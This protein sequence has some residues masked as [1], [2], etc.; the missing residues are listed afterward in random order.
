MKETLFKKKKFSLRFIAFVQALGLV[1]YC[2]LVALLF[3]RGEK[4]FGPANNFFMPAFLLVI[5]AT[6]A[7]ICGLLVLGYPIILF[8]FKKEKTGALKLVVYTAAWLIF[9]IFLIIPILVIF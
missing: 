5:F 1:V 7:L 8:W 6:S 3:W 9:F 2:G 4:W